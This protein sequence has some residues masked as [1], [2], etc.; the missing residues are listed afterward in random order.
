MIPRL[1]TEHAKTSN[2]YYTIKVWNNLPVADR[3]L[4]TIS[5]FKQRIKVVLEKLTE[6]N[7]SISKHDPWK[8]SI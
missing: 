4:L 3:E 1:N 5:R 7:E 8:T 6:D 2:S